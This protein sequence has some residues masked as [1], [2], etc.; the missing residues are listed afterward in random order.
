M[1][2]DPVGRYTRDGYRQRGKGKKERRGLV[3][4]KKGLA[5]PISKCAWAIAESDSSAPATIQIK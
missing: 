3:R 4:T 2:L 1:D 5:T